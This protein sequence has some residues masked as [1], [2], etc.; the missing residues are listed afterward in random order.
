MKTD[1]TP[2]RL[3]GA[4]RALAWAL[5]ST[6]ALTSPLLAQTTPPPLPSA[7]GQQQAMAQ[8]PALVGSIAYMLGTVSFHDDQQRDWAPAVINYPFSTGDELWTEPDGRAEMLVGTTRLRLQGTTQLYAA[9]LD[10]K[11]QSY[12]LSRGRL[13]LKVGTMIAGQT[14]EVV[15]PRGTAILA[16]NG[17][18]VIEAGTTEDPTRIGV[19]SGSA[20]F[21]ALNNKEFTLTANQVGTITG[22]QEQ[23]QFEMLRQAPPPM[24]QEWAARDRIYTAKPAAQSYTAAPDLTGVNELSYYGDWTS[25]SQYGRIWSPRNVAS[26]WAPYRYGH[27]SYVQPWGWTWIDDAPWGFAP[28]HYGRWVNIGNRWHW[29]PPQERTRTVYAPAVVGFLDN[30]SLDTAVGLAAGAALASVAW[31]A[32]GPRDVYVP[33]YTRDRDYIRYMNR[34]Y[35]RDQREIDR[36]LDYLERR[37]ARRDDREEQR[38]NSD[39]RR[40]ASAVRAEDFVRSRPV[41]L[42]RLQVRPEQFE[43]ARSELISAPVID[44]R[45]D[46]QPSR[47]GQPAGPQRTDR[48]RRAVEVPG[49]TV[50]RSALG[51]VQVL[52][53]PTDQPRA[54]APGPQVDRPPTSSD[55]PRRGENDRDRARTPALPA[56][57]R[58]ASAPAGEERRPGTALPDREPGRSPPA[59]LPSPGQTDRD[60]RPGAPGATPD[61]DQPGRQAVPNPPDREDRDGRPPQAAT[62]PAKDQPG[63][64]AVPT[65]PGRE[66]R[67]G[68]PPQAGTPPAKDEP[69]RQAVPTPP[70]REDRDGRPPQAATPPAKDEPGRQAVPTPPGQQRREQGERATPP[71]PDRDRPQATPGTP[72][73]PATPPAAQGREGQPPG[74]TAP[75]REAQPGRQREEQPPRSQAQPPQPGRERDAA[76]P[77]QQREPAQPPRTQAQPPQQREAAPSP[78]P[79]TQP[80]QQREREAAQPPRPERPPAA[81]RAQP[82]Q[83]QERPPQVAQPPERREAPPP[84]EER[85]EQPPQKGG[86]DQRK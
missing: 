58:T 71:I 40:W 41:S 44:R 75:G 39:N 2:V 60:G 50:A 20:R 1:P 74:A 7:Q 56:P 51:D 43:K 84:R 9:T 73:R 16:A 61:K 68:R 29:V 6:T 62:P 24:P 23:A 10:D 49:A 3:R 48:D 54:A 82:Q 72:A 52:G 38:W 65:P 78:R 22:T 13:D 28:S 25:N 55:R 30:S 8:P 76:Q 63:R 33:W 64:Q 4:A 19:R 5:I 79:Q 26:D 27:W 14:L 37:D 12:E 86:D 77:P 57:P 15:T 53:K 85:R 45:D 36:R 67:D 34:G 32:L 46:R 81:E 35:I 21:R 17:D 42:E 31:Y 18:Y 83:R 69:G 80:P 66:D 47:P 59:A 70:G 11:V